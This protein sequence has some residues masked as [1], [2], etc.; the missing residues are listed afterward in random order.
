LRQVGTGTE[1]LI[2]PADDYVARFV[3]DVN[4]ARI[5]TCGD[6]AVPGDEVGDVS[7]NATQTI[8]DAFAVL[9]ASDTPIAVCHAK[10]DSAG[11]LTRQRVFDALE[12]I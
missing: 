6:L 11:I 2:S 3:R 9:A 1:F 7:L 5:V 8:N 4:R 12:R 10:G